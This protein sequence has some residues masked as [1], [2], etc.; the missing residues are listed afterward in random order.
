MK[1]I[2]VGLWSTAVA[3]QEANLGSEEVHGSHRVKMSEVR[4]QHGGLISAMRDPH[5]SLKDEQHSGSYFFM[6]MSQ[7]FYEVGEEA[8]AR[9]DL[10]RRAALYE[11]QQIAKEKVI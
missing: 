11:R 1:R 7:A 2:L 5:F 10:A 3:S 6:D 4:S 8:E 9:A